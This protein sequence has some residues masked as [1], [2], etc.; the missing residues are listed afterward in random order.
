[1]GSKRRVRFSGTG[2]LP[3]HRT[4][5]CYSVAF[6][7]SHSSRPRYPCPRKHCR[8]RK[9]PQQD[10]VSS[11]TASLC[12]LR[13]DTRQ[14]NTILPLVYLTEPTCISFYSAQFTWQGRLCT[15][16]SLLSA[17]VSPVI[18]CP[19]ERFPPSTSTQPPPPSTLS[20]SVRCWLYQRNVLLRILKGK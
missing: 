9:S 18:S 11:T 13:H 8:C 5:P 14:G 3:L 4:P 17:T 16:H 20:E 2:H 1:M 10:T 6:L 19:P 7:G 15:V 12:C